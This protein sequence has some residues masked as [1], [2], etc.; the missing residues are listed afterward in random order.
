MLIAVAATFA[1][2]L[3]SGA[4]LVGALILSRR[5]RRFRAGQEAQPS[6]PQAVRCDRVGRLRRG[7][8]T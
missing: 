3:L 4:A 6:Q 5:A 1:F 8:R 2:F 7:P